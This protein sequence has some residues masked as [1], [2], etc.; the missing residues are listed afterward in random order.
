MRNLFE[1]WRKFVDEAKKF[2][3]PPATQDA[4]LNNENRQNAINEAKYGP[5]N[6]GEENEKF[7][8][9]YADKWDTDIKEAKSMRCHNC[10]FFNVS[11]QMKDCMEQAIVDDEYEQWDAGGFGFCHKFDFMCRQERT[12]LSWASGGPRTG[13]QEMESED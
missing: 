2:V 1:N 13:E 10:S 4:S 11:P 5:A 9:F 7:W 12:C 6:P 8:S 3:C